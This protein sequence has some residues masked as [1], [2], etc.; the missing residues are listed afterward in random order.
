MIKPLP[1]KHVLLQVMTDDLPRV[2]LTLAD[3]GLF[4][5]DY[6]PFEEENFPIIPG[7]HYRELFHQASSRLE[8]IRRNIPL[9]EP[10]ELK[11]IHVVGEEELTRYNNWLGT[12][13]ERCSQFEETFRELTSEERMVDQLDQAL[14]NFTALNID[15]SLIHGEKH[16]LDIHLGMVPRDN[17]TQLKEAVALAGY[18]LFVYMA[19]GDND[20]VIILGPKSEKEKEIVSV[21][22]TAG[23]RPLPV[24]AE[25][26]DE[27]ERVRQDLLDRK[28]KVLTERK[29]QQDD[30]S[31]C[32]DELRNELETAQ[33]ILIMAEPFVTLETAARSS[34]RLTVITG[35][36]PARAIKR[37]RK[38]LTRELANPFCLE[39]RDSLREERHLVPSY[40]PT[41]KMASPFHTLVKQ[42]GI[43]RYGEVDPTILFSLTF[44][45]MFGMMFGDIGHGLTLMLLAFLLRRKL[46]S[47]TLLG[48][49]AGASAAVFG[50]L[51]GS[52]FG[53]EELFHAVWIPPLSDPIYM[54]TAALLWG[55]GFLTLITFICIHNRFIEGDISRAVF[56]TNGLISILLYLSVLWGAYNFYASGSFGITAAILSLGSLLALLA[57]KLIE[58]HAPPGERMLVAFIETFETFTGYISNTLSFLRVAAFSLNHV[59]LAIAVFT[60]ADMMDT[61]GH[62][63]TVIG[64]N[65]F[66]LVLEGAIVTIQV[67]R[68]EY[69]EGFSRF[70]SGDGLEFKPLK[71]NQRGTA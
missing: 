54:L 31:A 13:W 50:V 23:F 58:T 47:F 39:T 25:L 16:F 40:L 38:A 48:I 43:P 18:M 10:L 7:E 71:L 14:D 28:Q 27:P 68:L 46:K 4:S 59:A 29:R 5:P 2:S 8:K 66:I 3:L 21:L 19:H 26:Q 45:A 33:R 6:R 69:Y 67:L 12:V 32:G 55:I 35:W 52:I 1:M 61:M 53:Y 15:L 9:R 44:I 36:L 65:I 62:W 17:I 64:G 57:Y 37:T 60:L 20:H 63:L 22:D 11:D 56:D 51:Y 41:G 42:Y 34:G 30:M 70:F 49:S 24:P